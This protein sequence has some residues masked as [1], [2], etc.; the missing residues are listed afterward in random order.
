M[1]KLSRTAVDLRSA[2]L[3]SDAFVLGELNRRASSG[4]CKT[5]LGRLP[6]PPI[7]LQYMLLTDLSTSKTREINL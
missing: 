4:K 3:S 7:I 6:H 1:G 5:A 2:E